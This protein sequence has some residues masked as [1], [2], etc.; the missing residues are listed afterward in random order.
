MMVLDELKTYWQELDKKVENSL[1]INEQLMLTVRAD[2]SRSTLAA[3]QTKVA[4]T[5]LFFA[6]LIA[7]FTAILLG[8]P[9]DYTRPVHYLPA[10]LY[11]LLLGAGFTMAGKEYL[12]LRRLN[13]TKSNLRE[14]LFIV[15][16]SHK[17]YQELMDNL[18]KLSLVAGF[19]LGISLLAPRFATYSWMKIG[20]VIVAHAVTI[21]LLYTGAK[22]LLKS[23]PDPEL[24]RLETILA[25]LEEA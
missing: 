18:W 4:R 2:Q 15:I 8:N 11:L 19:M 3:L 16:S 14:S 13:L 1:N 12:F 22:W 23:L 21:L 9:F 17:R 20:L 24:L 10:V 5:G 7:V 6:V 25:E